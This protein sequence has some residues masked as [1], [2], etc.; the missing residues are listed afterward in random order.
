M[1]DQSHQYRCT[2]IRG[3]SQKDIDNYLPAYAK[4]I[5]D[6]CP[7]SK[8]MFEQQFNERMRPLVPGNA[9]K[10]TL[11]NH[12][13]EIA[14]KLFGMYYSAESDYDGELY[15]YPGERTLKFLEDN[16]Q[17]AFFKDVCFKMQFPNG[18]TKP[19]TVRERIDLNISIRQC[20][21]IMEVLCEAERRGLVLTKNDLGYFVLNS[22]DALQRIASPYEIVDAIQNERMQGRDTHDI[23]DPMKESSYNLQ[24]IN[25][26][27]NYMELANLIIL[28]P[29]GDVRV[30]QHESAAVNIFAEHWDDT[31]VFDVT[32]FD[33]SSTHAKHFFQNAWDEYYSALSDEASNFAT[34]VTALLQPATPSTQSD[35]QPT[36]TTSD[37]T[38]LGDEGEQYVYDYEKK[39]VSAFNSRLANKVLALGKTRGLG[40]DIQTVV[41]KPGTEAEFVK[42]VEVKATKRV[43]APDINDPLWIDTV[44]ITRNEWVAAQQHGAYYSIYRVYFVRGGVVMY[45]IE[46]PYQLSQ[47][48]SLSVVPTMYRMDF[49]S[50]AI[51]RV[52]QS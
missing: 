43:T 48:G 15:I 3:K 13:T 4:I 22:L 34:S 37:T 50:S 47:D 30:N 16:D 17:P 46:N 26:Q 32:S 23:G 12:R 11:D 52:I 7:C 10:K 14:G 39:R 19:D 2:I 28:S 18:M 44:N 38:E 27:L 42:Y 25:E 40:Y 33:L 45:V 31:P 9:T 51:D 21:F 6:I 36:H 29:D 20:C 24:H 49:G 1:Y 8:T 35:T 41:A 5:S